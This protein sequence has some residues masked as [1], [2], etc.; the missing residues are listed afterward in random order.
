MTASRSPIAA[1]MN[2]S[3]SPVAVLST[4]LPPVS[5]EP[6]SATTQMTSSTQMSASS[7]RMNRSRRLIVV[8][9]ARR[10]SANPRGACS[11]RMA[12][13]RPNPLRG[14]SSDRERALSVI[15]CELLV[16]TYHCDAHLR[17]AIKVDRAKWAPERSIP[18]HV[19]QNK[20]TARRA[21]R[22][23]AKRARRGFCA[24]SSSVRFGG[25]A[26]AVSRRGQHDQLVAASKSDAVGQNGWRDRFG[27]RREQLAATSK[28]DAV[29]QRESQ[30]RLQR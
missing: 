28:S 1:R 20:I 27:G 7:A 16:L 8:A 19:Q 9:P 18:K 24:P 26:V 3:P 17:T 2:P 10:P 4:P 25:P 13:H 12:L 29:G 11:T 21:A 15:E 6:A 14:T 5:P 22:R 23:R 30:P